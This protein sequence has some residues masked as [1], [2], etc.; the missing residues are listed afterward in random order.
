MKTRL[1]EIALF[2]ALLGVAFAGCATKPYD[3]TNFR[4]HPPRSIVVLPPLN[5]T[6]DIAGTY[7]YLSTVT[8]PIAELGYYVYPVAV[9]DHFF[10]NILS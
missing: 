6:T 10:R 7:S 3:Y 8:M 9:V 2:G 5:E 4:A 1:V